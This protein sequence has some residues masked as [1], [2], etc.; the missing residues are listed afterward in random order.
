MLAANHWTDHRDPTGGVIERTEG[1][2]GVCSPI[3][4]TTIW[5]NQYP[6]SSQG[7]NHQ[8]RKIHGDT[9]EPMVPAAYVAEDGLLGHQWEKKP[10]L[11]WK[12]DA[13][14]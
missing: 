11:L 4:G 3:G 1:A 10:L 5:T 2:E 13:P 6:Q 7:V 12:I 14:G 8:P 9:E